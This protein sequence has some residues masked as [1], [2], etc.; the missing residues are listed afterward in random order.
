MFLGLSVGPCRFPA[1]AL[2][3]SVAG[4]LADLVLATGASV[5][6]F[7]YVIGVIAAVIT[8]LFAGPLCFF[9]DQLKGTKLREWLSHDR[10]VLEQLR[11]FEQKWIGQSGQADMLKVPDFS[12]VIDLNST[13]NTVH[14][15]TKLPFRRSQLLEVIV[16]ALLPFLPILALQIPI[17][18]LLA[19]Y[20]QLL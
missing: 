4:G 8:I 3:A 14:Q 7:K 6:S 18:G 16:A 20:K 19:M 1:F 13:V 2:A 11:Q 12:A 10:T 17:K 5:V 15:M 9:C